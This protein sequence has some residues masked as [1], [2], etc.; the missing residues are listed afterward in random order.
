MTW[1]LVLAPCVFGNAAPDFRK[2]PQLWQSRAI[3]GSSPQRYALANSLLYP[4]CPGERGQ[5]R[6]ALFGLSFGLW[7]SLFCLACPAEVDPC[8]LSSA[9]QVI[10]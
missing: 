9:P 10:M 2:N 7:N 6:V 4:T 8:L 3:A 5:C 1:R